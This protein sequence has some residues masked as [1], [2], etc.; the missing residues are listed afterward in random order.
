MRLPAVA[1]AAAFACGI[2]LALYPVEIWK[3]PW[4]PLVSSCLN[5]ELRFHT[6]WLRPNKN[7]A[8]LFSR[9]SLSI[10]LGVARIPRGLRRGA[11]ATSV[12]RN[13]TAGKWASLSGNAPAVAWAF[14]R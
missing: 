5:C 13:V 6:N 8:P 12:R 7:R 14:A 11:D 1:I 2:A 10:E 3:A 9:C 4:V